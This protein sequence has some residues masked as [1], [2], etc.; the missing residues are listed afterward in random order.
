MPP[1]A[2][3]RVSRVLESPWIGLGPVTD[4]F[5][6]EFARAIGA[7]H[8][9]G[10]SSGTA[11]L[12]LGL[13]LIGAGPG[14]EVILPANT[15]VA[16]GHAV[17]LQGATPV[18][19]DID[20]ATGNLDPAQLRALLGPRTVAVIPVHYAGAPCETD[21]IHTLAADAGV[22]V[23]EDC[24]HAVGAR[25]NGRPLGASGVFQAYS[26]HATK[27]LAI[28]EGGALVVPD[29]QQAARA[30]R[31]RRFGIDKPD[32]PRSAAQAWDYAV[33]EVGYKYNM[34]DIQAAIG[35]AQLEVLSKVLRRRAEAAERYAHHLADIPGVRIL[36]HD[37]H[38]SGNF[39]MPVLA[40]DRDRLMDGL[41]A[42]GIETGVH[43]RRIDSYPMYR[44]ADLPHTERF[45]RHQLSLPL[46]S[47]LTT[48]DVD[49]VC[50]AVAAC[51]RS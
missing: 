16:T 26:F 37:R 11:A 38:A 49:R 41:A 4:E 28:G 48:D 3:E 33:D 15:F 10:V 31:L 32:A 40:E 42:Y 44:K 5:E 1:G 20:P 39:L 19:A 29:G 46:H 8:V 51:A 6:T 35:L 13:R 2:K 17:L 45:W 43:F 7:R 30:R 50:E 12:H 27:S 9:V 47:A 14:D 21:A 34:G 18:F 23:L 24:A 25:R 22:A 36:D